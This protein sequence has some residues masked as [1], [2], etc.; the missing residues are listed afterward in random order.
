M[1][2]RGKY[3]IF[4]LVLFLCLSSLCLVGAAFAQPIKP[5]PPEFTVRY[6]HATY[7]TVNPQTGATRQF[8]NS[9]IEFRI[10]NQP[11]IVTSTVNAIYY[12]VRFRD[13]ATGFWPELHS[14]AT[15]HIQSNGTYTILTIPISL[16]NLLPPPVQNASSIDFQLQ[17]QTGYYSQSYQQGQMP[18]APLHTDGYWEIRFNPA[19]KSDWSS[20]QTVNLDETA[21]SSNPGP[22]AP[23]F[24]WLAVLLLFLSLLSAALVLLRH[25]N[26]VKSRNFDVEQSR[27]LYWKLFI[28]N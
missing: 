7:N 16:P 8:D 6:V 20:T 1:G 14:T 5:S 13:P 27:S 3:L 9:S 10:K 28:T 11:F 21:T 15:Y 24:S 4:F 12:L 22:T 25:R 26:L 18:G 23:E 2:R 17:A 19:E